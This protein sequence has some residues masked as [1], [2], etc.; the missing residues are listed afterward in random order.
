MPL[1]MWFLLTR[2]VLV[3]AVVVLIVWAILAYSPNAWATGAQISGGVAT[4]IVLMFGS[5][6]FLWRKGQRVDELEWLIPHEM[7][8]LHGGDYPI[9]IF[10]VLGLRRAHKAGTDRMEPATSNYK[11]IHEVATLIDEYLF[12]V[13]VLRPFRRKFPDLIHPRRRDPPATR[14]PEG[15]A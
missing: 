4:T 8:S 14:D 3:V 9:S 12:W 13:A 1:L 7:A 5:V 6:A 15:T 2:F 11:H 10:Y